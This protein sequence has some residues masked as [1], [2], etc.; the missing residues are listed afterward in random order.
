MSWKP[1]YQLQGQRVN[2]R[3]DL[4][5]SMLIPGSNVPFSHQH[6]VMLDN[7]ITTSVIILDALLA[8]HHGARITEAART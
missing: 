1:A 4:H 3:I 2:I 8:S 7:Y 5:D 6:A